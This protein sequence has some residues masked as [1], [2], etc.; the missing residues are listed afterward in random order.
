VLIH[1]GS[2]GIGTT[3]IQLAHAFGAR[4]LTTVGTA[5]KAAACLSLGA[6]RAIL[7]GEEDFVTV[8]REMTGNRGIDVILDM[9]GGDYIARDVEALAVEGRLVQ[10]A[11][12]RASRVDFD[13]LPMMVKR[14]T[15][16]GSTLRPRS[17][18]Q[19]GAIAAALRSNVWPLIE[20]GRVRPIIHTT[21]PLAE[22]SQAHALM[23]S[24][25]HIGKIVLDCS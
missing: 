17:V 9:V 11:F 8:A 4:V 15:I 19:K 3:A 21:F 24:G 14:L 6:E 10:I 12:Q 1:G 18:A 2:S 5:E 7:Y 20:A 22:A 25:R 23:E 13:F 16:T